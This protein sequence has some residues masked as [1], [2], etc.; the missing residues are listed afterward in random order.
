MYDNFFSNIKF[1]FVLKSSET[2]AKKILWS[3][4]HHPEQDRDISIK[5]LKNVTKIV[6]SH[7]G[8]IALLR[9]LAF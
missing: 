9:Q 4:D 2:Y 7:V 1:F 5:M 8:Y 3:A 6:Y